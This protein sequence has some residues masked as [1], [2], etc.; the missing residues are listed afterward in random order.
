MKNKTTNLLG[1]SLIMIIFICL[2]TKAQKVI[3]DNT[4]IVYGSNTNTNVLSIKTD[5][6]RVGINTANPSQALEVVGK[7]LIRDTDDAVTIKTTHPYNLWVTDGVVAEDLFIVNKDNWADYVFDK[8]YDLLS[9]EEL[10][11]FIQ[12][13]NHLPNIPSAK[14]VREEGYS[15]HDINAK[16][17]SKIEELTLYTL[18]QENEL[19]KQLE[20]VN[21]QSKQI[22]DLIQLVENQNIET[23][24]TK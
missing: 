8:D 21:Q 23:L 17:L 3:S 24:K 16:L 9:L 18:Q 13:N 5:L 11:K 6:G 1:L 4:E 2:Q 20:V 7:V 15:Q 22:D 19:K 12:S 14:E 10:H